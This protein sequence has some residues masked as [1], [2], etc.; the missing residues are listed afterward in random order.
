[1]TNRRERRAQAKDKNNPIPLSQPSRNAPTHKTLIDVAS[2]RAAAL[3]G[4]P[5]S[6]TPSI[7]TTKMNPDGTL[8]S[9]ND[10]DS[11]KAEAEAEESTPLWLDTL[12]YTTSLTLLHFT[13]TFLVHHQYSSS[14]PNLGSL[15]YG[16]T[17]ISGA[18]FLLFILVYILHPRAS[19][20]P[21]QV[22]FGITNVIT[23][24][25]L[26]RA[27]NEDPYLAVMKKAPP[28]GVIWVWA[29]IEL[30][31]EVALPGLAVVGGYAWWFG[32]GYT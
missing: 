24:I 20:L 16:S 3:N 11:G 19:Q 13:L 21:V 23:G 27:S 10:I 26:V 15:L 4:T 2:E 5:S 1:M 8:S 6:D 32:Y 14:P 22:L 7:T 31:W 29:V 9:P 12:L 30:R 28:L 18:P 25:W 17:V